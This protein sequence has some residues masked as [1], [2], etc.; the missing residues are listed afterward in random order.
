MLAVFKRLDYLL[1]V[2]FIEEFSID[3]YAA[4]GQVGL[5]KAPEL[6]S[7]QADQAR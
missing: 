2:F 3:H 1:F 4:L 7:K 5:L 6:V